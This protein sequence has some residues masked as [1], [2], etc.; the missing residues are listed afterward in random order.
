MATINN[1]CINA[2]ANSAY[3]SCLYVLMI[4]LIHCLRYNM[5]HLCGYHNDDTPLI[6]WEIGYQRYSFILEYLA[7]DGR[8]RQCLLVTR[9]T[10]SAQVCRACPHH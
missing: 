6:I 7:K 10:R 2:L 1:S 3:F 5:S 9:T 4:P 8:A